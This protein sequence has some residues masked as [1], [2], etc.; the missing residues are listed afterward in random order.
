MRVHLTTLIAAAIGMAGG[1]ACEK[2]TTEHRLDGPMRLDPG[3]CGETSTKYVSGHKPESFKLEEL[4]NGRVGS[5][6]RSFGVSGAR[7]DGSADK[8]PDQ[9]DGSDGEEQ[10]SGPTLTVGKGAS[11]GQ[12]L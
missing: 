9:L 5:P 4:K 12:R 7:K 11:R 2:T 6:Y 3:D 8:G 10:M 1:M